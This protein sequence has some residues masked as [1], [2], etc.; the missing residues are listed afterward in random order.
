MSESDSEL[1]TAVLEFCSG[2]KEELDVTTFEPFSNVICPYCGVETRVKRQLGNYYLERRYAIG[3]MSVVY[4]A[5]DQTLDREVA[6]KVLNEDYSADETRV[7]AF[8]S[9]ARLT[10]AVNHPNVVQVYTVGRAYD[11]FYLVMELIGGQSFEAVMGERGALPEDEVLDIA[12][13]VTKGL[14]AANDAGVLHRDVKPGNILLSDDGRTKLV[15]FGLALITQGGS[16]TAEEVWATPYYVPP[17]ALDRST[18][19]FRSDLYAFGATLYHALA[20]KPP[21][22][23]TTNGTKVLRRAKQTI[24][25]LG[26]VAPWLGDATCE[27]IDRMM[28]YQPKHRWGSYEEV[29]SILR[30][31]RNEA[32]DACGLEDV[33]NRAQRRARKNRWLAPT[34]AIVVIGGFAAALLTLKPWEKEEEKRTVIE[35]KAA[36]MIP[37][38]ES[39]DSNKHLTESWSFARGLVAKDDFKRAEAKFLELS[40]DEALG[41]PTRSFAKIEAGISASLDGRAGDARQY[42]REVHRYLKKLPKKNRASE[43]L[44]HLAF[45]LSKTEP[46]PARDLSD[47]PKGIVDWMG[48]TAL[49]LKLWEQGM[50]DEAQPLLK[51]IKD[52]GIR[53]DFD[54]FSVYQKQTDKYLHDASLIAKANAKPLP[55]THKEARVLLDDLEHRLALIQ[56][57]GRIRFNI[58]S[59][60][61]YLTRLR[62]G[63]ELRPESEPTLNFSERIDEVR[64]RAGE[65]RFKLAGELIYPEDMADQ[66]AVVTA[67]TYLLNQGSA[68]LAELG[69][70]PSWEGET[71][72]GEVLKFSGLTGEGAEKSDGGILE[73]S[74]IKTKSLMAVHNAAM[75]AQTNIT[76]RL[77]MRE[78][79]IAFAWLSGMREAAEAEAEE[80]AAAS[81]EFSKIWRQ[82]LVGISQ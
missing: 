55:R 53:K 5:T 8:E 60:Q 76:E 50:F 68:F 2:C 56:T 4:L 41:E 9:E 80:F 27:A 29:L 78:Q 81:P 16:A 47:E 65:R 22:E 7:A 75:G 42:A 82:V 69:K 6:V 43:K 49:T 18:E 33:G 26:K 1:I 40:K 66:A 72:S 12:L 79:A 70:V 13:Q 10:A 19:D 51:K 36:E 11:R 57:R 64:E 45:L 48:L 46:P 44:E 25:R 58:R 3:G 63:F 28:V 38:E 73:L 14:R 24:P 61:I 31:A 71:T 15:D 37:V 34:A 62:K 67:W 77:A 20:G 32:T 59:K 39:F 23:S 52:A 74:Q 17:E 54:W 30:K 35:P 21:F